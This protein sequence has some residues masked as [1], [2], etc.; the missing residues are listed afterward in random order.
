LTG[1]KKIAFIGTGGTI[2]SLGLNSLDIVYYGEQKSMLEAQA[3]I[4]AVPEVQDVAQVIAVPFANVPS[5]EI[6]FDAWTSL[7]TLCSKI[8]A[9]DPD[10]AGIVIGHGTATLEETAYFLGLTVKVDVPV[11]VVG[12]QRPLSGLSTDARMNLVNAVRVAASPASVGR[13]VLVLLN[14]EIHAAREVTKTATFRLQTF[15]VPDFGML[16]YVDG[17][18]VAYYRRTERV[19]APNTE[20]DVSSLTAL[21]RV[22]IS[23]AYAGADGAEVDAYVSAG[24]RGIISAGFAP[25][26]ATPAQLEALARARKAGVVIVQGTRAGSGIVH[27]GQRL[28]DLDFITSDNLNPQKAR[29]L[30]SLALTVSDDPDVL[31]RIFATY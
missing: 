18:T 29:I 6:Y 28:K 12:S 21:P 4:D 2:S 24:A 3:I 1:K 15:R 30:L 9:D 8:V 26:M 17:D 16:G 23:Y 22:D 13:G 5:T 20:F 25:G 11:V 7:V 19:T 10:I 31:M 14:D 27:R